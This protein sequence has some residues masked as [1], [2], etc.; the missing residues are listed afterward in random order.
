MQARSLAEN[1]K[2][3]ISYFDAVAEKD[4]SCREN[5]VRA[6]E[7]LEDFLKKAEGRT[8]SKD[9][10]YEFGGMLT[11]GIQDWAWPDPYAGEIR[12]RSAKALDIA[13]RETGA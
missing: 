3:F 7:L 1:I 12:E 9:D 6:K 5:C 13:Y 8:F 11:K 2:D 10:A 4:P